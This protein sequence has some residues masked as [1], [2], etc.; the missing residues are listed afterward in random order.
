MQL[1]PFQKQA[2]RSFR[3]NP[4]TILI[5]STGSGKSLVFQRFL[6]QF[7]YTRAILIVP[8]NALARQHERRFRDL[9]IPVTQGVGSEGEGPPDGPGVWILNPEKIF[10][11]YQNSIREWAPDV[12]IVDEAHC[13]WEWGA[14]FRPEFSRVPELVREFSIPKSFWCTAT[15][16]KE[17]LEQIVKGLPGKPHVLG[18][19][20]IP[21]NLK[22][23]RIRVPPHRRM[24]YL[25]SK[26]MECPE[27]SG[28]IFVSTRKSSERVQAFLGLWGI[29]V[30]SYHAGMSREERLNL[31]SR[32]AFQGRTGGRIWVVA[33]SAFGMGMDYPFLTRCILFE[34]S[35]SLLALSQALGRV[36]RAGVAARAEVLWHENDFERHSWFYE[37]STQNRESLEEVRRWCSTRD[38]QRAYLEKYF[39]EGLFSGKMD[40]HEHPEGS[41]R[42]D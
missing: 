14:R 19:F 23:E 18:Q 17:A 10:H 8:L 31:E 26:L 37:G 39:N 5:S 11:R 7:K 9:G 32:L 41:K 21:E 25:R 42:T 35:F 34:P 4:H 20:E 38:C 3:E 22:I 12:L 6:Q 24:E 36:G 33:T 2:L 16:P 1:K 30:V 29:P 13:V 40:Q 15:L 28:M 27:V